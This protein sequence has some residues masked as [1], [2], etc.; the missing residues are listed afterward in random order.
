MIQ[1][2]LSSIGTSIFAVMS[3]KA[4]QHNAINLSQGFP[5]FD[6]SQELIN[7][8]DKYMKK[9][10]NQYAPIEGVM[11]LREKISEKIE[12]LH[13]RKYSP[14]NEILVTAG[15]TQAIY[16]TITALVREDDE[17]LIFEPAYDCYVPAIKLNG[18]RPIYVQLKHPDYYIDWE[19]VKHLISSRTKLIILNTPQNPSGAVL[20]VQDLEKL[21]KLVSGTNILILS[22]EVYE[23]IIFDDFEHQSIARFPDLAKR[24]IIVSSFGKTYHNTGWRMGYCLAP[25]E[26]MKELV[27]I[28]QYSVYNVNTPIQYALAEYMEKEDRYLELSEFYQEKRD[29][30]L[31]QLEGSQYEIIPSQGTY[32][33][34]LDY[35]KL[36]NEKD[37]DFAERLIKEY[38]IA[39]IPVSVFYHQ[40]IDNKVLRFCF[41]KDNETLKKAAECLLKVK[42][43]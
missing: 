27:K 35:S 2:K 42:S 25:A 39:S 36:S 9:G 33:Q 31:E 19:E 14:E 5:N 13:G 43:L 38:G 40:K 7:L 11:P 26:I 15:A 34:L 32:F 30:F 6:C 21:K 1:S 20:S 12:K 3:K 16:N 28:H 10:C 17:V 24:S 8:V 18:G 22:D 29:F 41:A 37:K 4:Q 23:H